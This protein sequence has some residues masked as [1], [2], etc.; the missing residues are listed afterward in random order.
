MK[1]SSSQEAPSSAPVT[2]NITFNTQAEFDAFL[3][4]CA[5]NVIVANVVEPYIS[6]TI[7]DTIKTVLAVM[8]QNL[9]KYED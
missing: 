5:Y 8:Y 4:V 7:H 3:T 6:P 9:R 1:I 2:C